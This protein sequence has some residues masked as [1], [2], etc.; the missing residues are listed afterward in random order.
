MQDHRKASMIKVTAVRDVDYYVKKAA[1]CRDSPL[2]YY[3]GIK[4]SPGRWAG[5]GSERL[6]LSGGLTREAAD[7]EFK[8]L[9][10]DGMLPGESA[11]SAQEQRT[12]PGWDLTVS[13]PKSV[14]ILAGVGDAHVSAM[15][16]DAHEAATAAAI[17]YMERSVAQVRRGDGGHRIEAAV[18]G[19]LGAS[20]RH[21]EAR[22]T[23]GCDCGD[24]QLHSHVVIAN[25][26]QSAVDGK[27]LAIH[28]GL[29]FD[30]QKTAGY[31]YQAELRR[32]LT[33]RLGVAWRPVEQGMAEIAGVK[34]EWLRTFSKRSAEA[35]EHNAAL[36][37]TCASAAE[38]EAAV[39]A[40]RR[41]K[42]HQVD[43]PE[44]RE[45]WQIEADAAGVDVAAESIRAKYAQRPARLAVDLARLT[46]A[47]SSFTRQDVI[48]A[49]AASARTGAACAEIEAEVD[50]VLDD[51]ELVPVLFHRDPVTGQQMRGQDPREPRFTTRAQLELEQRVLDSAARRRGEGAAVVDED[52]VRAAF[53][54]GP[55]VLGEDQAAAVRALLR[56]G[57]GVALVIAAAG[58]GKT[59]ALSV[60]TAAWQSAGVRV[61]GCAAGG[62][63][64]GELAERTGMSTSTIAQTFVDLT[65][66]EG[67]PAGGVLV[68][69]EA[70]MVGTRDLSRL[71]A[72]A[73]A[74]RTKLVLVGDPAQ[75]QPVASGGIVR[76]LVAQNGAAELTTNRRQQEEWQQDALDSIRD[77]HGA[78]GLD[79][80]VTEGRV[81]VAASPM[82]AQA[83]CVADYWRTARVDPTAAVMVAR[84]NADVAALN[85][86][87]QQ[88]ARES[89]RLS[90]PVAR[91]AYGEI[92]GGDRVVA[93]DTTRGRRHG[94]CNG[95]LGVVA[96]VQDGRLTLDLDKGGR[97]E[98]PA[99][100][101]AHV[102]LGYA[103]TA[104][105]AQGS[106]V[107]RAFVYGS[108]SREWLYT[109]ASRHREDVHLY[110]SSGAD[111]RAEIDLPKRDQVDAIAAARRAVS[112]SE[113]KM[114][115]VDIEP[116]GLGDAELRDQIERTADLL[117]HRPPLGVAVPVVRAEVEHL[118]QDIEAERE[119]VVAVA[120]VDKGGRWRRGGTTTA[121]RSTEPLERLVGRLA[122]A[123]ERLAE[124]EGKVSERGA[125][126]SEHML[127]LA[128]GVEAADE[129]G[130]RQQAHNVAAE[131]E[132]GGEI[133]PAALEW[134]A[135]ELER[136]G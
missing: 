91:N 16:R 108:G 105:R 83:A 92:N 18:P 116:K 58:T 113:A 79:R 56:D 10:E 111:D 136:V 101:T 117:R 86:L 12:V 72:A 87:A 42:G 104:H 6:G 20:F 122:T 102:S 8:R 14:S 65:R 17:G 97:V 25:M 34:D 31:I 2:E 100:Y 80:F 106:T 50:Q 36:G 119:R 69:D 88:V 121:E 27:W 44:L 33:E 35:A 129:L 71:V 24:P 133:E 128:R 62:K 73:E 90:G 68:V 76:A 77:G 98:L 61:V 7:G 64:A 82:A 132:W 32:E 125:W 19:F 43:A 134:D 127:G 67:L 95:D 15:A 130:W 115:A 66:G 70:G 120:S 123:Q 30:H 112:Q 103:L 9:I 29:L 126:D 78:A 52:L 75:L 84:S 1:G 96:E 131:I 135:P 23:A 81:T 46:E 47:E 4:E 13:A 39:L 118:Q 124:A 59:T 107:D 51:D 60:A 74:A 94:V 41:P 53:D 21:R 40:T 99:S 63:A 5:A 11:S 89:G 45:R 26:A 114:A 109:A 110:L 49:M 48:R 55:L 22:P 93:R 38:M 57:D 54:A 37:I 85:R 28:G 3:A